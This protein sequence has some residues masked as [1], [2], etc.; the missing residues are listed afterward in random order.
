LTNA[1]LSANIPLNKLGTRW[2]TWLNA[3]IYY[4]ERFESIK[5]AVNALDSEDAIY[6]KKVLTVIKSSSLHRNLI[7]IKAHFGTFPES[8]TKLQNSW[9]DF[10]RI[11]KNIRR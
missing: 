11:F 1:F 3:S 9:T 5:E 4:C 6:I 2:G 8:I 10:I 7:Y